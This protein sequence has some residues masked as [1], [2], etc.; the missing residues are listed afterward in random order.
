MDIYIYFSLENEG[1]IDEILENKGEV[2]D[3]R[4]GI[5]GKT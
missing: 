1:D 5:M 4:M 3:S 2:T